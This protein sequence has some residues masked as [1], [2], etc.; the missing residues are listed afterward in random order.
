VAVPVEGV[1]IEEKLEDADMPE[2]MPV[3]ELVPLSAEL[4]FGCMAL[5]VVCPIAVRGV[6]PGAIVAVDAEVVL[7]IV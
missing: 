6:L 4:E 7:G 1:C 2:D 5:D 3:V